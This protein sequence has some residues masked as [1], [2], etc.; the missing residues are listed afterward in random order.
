MS[1]WQAV[2]GLEIHIQLKTESK[3]FSTAPVQFGSD[4]NCNASLVDLGYPGTLP[5]PNQKV[6]DMAI[7]FGLAM[8]CEVNSHSQF[9]R[10]NYFYPDLPKGYQTT[11]TYFPIIGSGTIA[12]QHNHQQFKTRIHH[13]HLEEDAGKS[14][15]DMFADLSAIDLNRAGTPLI[16]LVTEPDLRS[17]G[18]AVEFLRYIHQ[19]I[20]YLKISDGDMSQGS[21]RCDANVSIRR[22]G[23]TS[24]GTRAELKNINSFRFVGQAIDIEIQRQIDVLE[25]GGK[26]TQETR[27]FDERTQQTR[28]MR[29]KEFENDYRYFPCPD[30]VPVYIPQEYIDQKRAQLIELPQAKIA[31]F[32]DVLQLDSTDAIN[33]C[34][35][36]ELAEYFE[37]IVSKGI[38]PQIACNWLLTDMAAMLNKHSVT[39][40][41][42]PVSVTQLVEI[43]QLVTDKTISRSMAKQLFELVW[44][45]KSDDSSLIQ[46]LLKKHNMVQIT[47]SSAIETIVDAVIANNPKQLQS[48]RDAPEDKRKKMVGFFVGQVMKASQGKA[49][50]QL[51]NQLLQQKLQ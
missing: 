5:I 38:A 41:N 16:E 51:V 45:A 39:I 34:K 32:C 40:D 30:L 25:S 24:L 28:S 15:H 33:L 23:D 46:N 17:S 8:G 47:D 12:L 22:V 27:L 2:I 31:R 10:K 6:F 4:A 49:N 1:D 48:Y 18:E 26:I 37:A 29:S 44:N 43:I 35:S 20:T 21:M 36:R 7:D 19:I 50:P 42:S 3:L 9:D 13:A 11:Q 14:V